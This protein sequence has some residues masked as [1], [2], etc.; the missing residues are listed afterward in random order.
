MKRNLVVLLMISL[1]FN[2]CVV[3]PKTKQ[4]VISNESSPFGFHTSFVFLDSYP[5]QSALD[6]GVAWERPALYSHWFLVQENKE[7]IEKGIFNFKVLDKIYGRVPVG[8]NILANI[9]AEGYRRK[10]SWLPYDEKAYTI[11]VEKVV[12]RYDGDGIDD[13]PGLK[14]PIKYWQVENEPPRGMMDFARHQKLTYNAIKEACSDCKVLIGGVPG[15]P[16]NYLKNFKKNY[17]P[18]LEEL[19]GKYFDIFDFHWYGNATGDYDTRDVYLELKSILDGFGFNGEIWIT[20]MGTYSG[21]PRF[22]EYQS[23]AQ[24]AQDLVKRFVVPL[25]LGVKK[26]FPAFGLM[27]GFKHDDSYFDHTGF[28]YDGKGS[29]DLGIGEKKL[30]Y[31][32]YKLMTEK[33][34]GSDWENIEIIQEKEN[35]YIYKFVKS[36]EVVYVVWWDWFNEIDYQRGKKKTVRITLD[37]DVK[38]VK[39]TEAV[40]KYDFG[41][42]VEDYSKAFREIKGRLLESYPLQLEFELGENP[43]FVEAFKENFK[44]E[45]KYHRIKLKIKTTSDW[46]SLE[47]LDGAKIING[48]HNIL[49]GKNA[50]N[51][52]VEIVPFFKRFFSNSVKINKK[53]FDPTLVEIEA[54][55]LLT[56]LQEIVEF[57]IVKG[58][59][60]YTEVELYNYNTEEEIFIERERNESLE[61]DCSITFDLEGG[62]FMRNGPLKQ[63]TKDKYE[64]LILAY[65]YIWYGK[66]GQNWENT[67]ALSDINPYLGHYSSDDPDVIREHIKV[68]KSSGIDGFIASWWGPHQDYIV[69]EILEISKKENFLISFD[70]EAL[71]RTPEEIFDMLL[72]LFENFKGE[73]EIL[74]IGDRMVFFIWG[75]WEHSPET[76]QRIFNRLESLGYNGFYLPSENMDS[77]YLGIL[78]GL[79]V[80]GTV[81]RDLDKT[82]MLGSIYCKTFSLLEASKNCLWAATLSPGYD[83]RRIEGRKGLYQERENG[84]YYTYTFEAAMRSDPDWLLITSFNELAE[85]THIEPTKEFGY[86]Y[87]DLTAGFAKEFKGKEY[88]PEHEVE[89]TNIWKM[90]SLLLFVPLLILV[91]YIFMKKGR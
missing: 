62:E 15:F 12:E 71:G 4:E 66:D 22:F 52:K 74:K 28:I 1:L 32:T 87:M 81:G 83:E 68:S 23:E 31:Y 51:L 29:K 77:S 86:L 82:Y 21:K 6:I 25:S 10:N 53:Q 88:F 64:K 72:H 60:G 58:C 43:L 48:K 19:D 11:F 79:N 63:K 61:G 37:K 84:E 38:R 65:Y 85:H 17:L 14:I 67:P 24:Q 54:V 7:E 34:E 26:I 49:K 33:L 56:D 75:T 50:P 39:I 78:Q 80:Y 16:Q 47:I 89:E 46:T 55:V 9:T 90:V 35:I 42:E 69:R 27:E 5:Y 91:S 44:L 40:P 36:E 13:M 3:K 30:S 45:R 8:I 70:V 20:E 73:D 2:G 57:R 18:I 41:K 76:W 59:M